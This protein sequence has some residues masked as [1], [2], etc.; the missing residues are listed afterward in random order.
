MGLILKSGKF[1]DNLLNVVPLEFGNKEQFAVLERIRKAQE[2]GEPMTIDFVGNGIYNA[3]VG[4]TCVC[5][6]PVIFDLQLD[7]EHVK[8]TCDCGI[9]WRTEEEGEVQIIAK[10]V[11]TKK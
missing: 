11:K 10:I 1:Y 7:M 9:T 6:Q 5:G 3:E 8:K 2:H 4:I